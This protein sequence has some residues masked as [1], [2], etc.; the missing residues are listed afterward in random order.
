MRGEPIVNAF[1]RHRKAGGPV[2]VELAAQVVARFRRRAYLPN[3]SR[4]AEVTRRAH[5]S[6]MPRIRRP[7][8]RSPMLA[9]T[10]LMTA[11]EL[12]AYRDLADGRAELVRGKLVVSEPP[13]FEHG[14]L[15]ARVCVSLS[16]FVR[17]A[18][19][20]GT[21]ALGKV[22]AGEPGFWIARNPDTVR[23]PDVAF[24]AADR[25][26]SGRTRG[27][28]ED[29]PTLAVEVL[30]PND[31]PGAILAKVGE[32]LEAGTMLVWTIDPERREA[33][34]YRADGSQATIV[35]EGLLSGEDV[36][37]GL[38]LPMATLLV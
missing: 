1:G 34:V 21:P 13:G 16:L 10:R 18:T 35:E 3:S 12:L 30:S 22:V 32:W 31:R 28:L 4:D 15:L 20:A 19:S 23:A 33:R 8:D 2:E 17:D 27:F 38:V 11:K 37:P 5:C 36:L 25:V 14:E 7:R 26:P 24:V 9:S 6:P 29:A